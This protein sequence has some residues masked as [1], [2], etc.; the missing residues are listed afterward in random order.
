MNTLPFARVRR[1]SRHHHG[2]CAG[3]AR[4]NRRRQLDPYGARLWA[5]GR[6]VLIS[7]KVYRE[8]LGSAWSGS[9]SFRTRN[10]PSA[11]RVR[12]SI[13]SRSSRI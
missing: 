3:A 6:R 1:R 9:H 13:T 10:S 8:R 5:P 11:L 2:L 7:A 4:Q 12:K